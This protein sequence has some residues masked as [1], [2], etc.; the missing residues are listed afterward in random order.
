[1]LAADSALADAAMKGDI[2]TV[3]TLLGRKV[4]VNAAQGDGSTAL[5]WAVYNGNAE[6]VQFLLTARRRRESHDAARRTDA[7]DDGGQE[8]RHR[9]HQAAARRKGR[10]HQPECERHDAA[11]VRCRIG[12]GRRRQAAA[13][14]RRRRQRHRCD[15]WPD[16]AD[17][18]GGTGPG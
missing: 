8:R 12:A 1:M 11:D 6:M 14:S 17:V 13:R 18:C 3:R 2:S 9:H 16:G 10:C 4:D 5:H 15:Q 7:V